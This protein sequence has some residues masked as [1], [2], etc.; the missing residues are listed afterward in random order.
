LFSESGLY[1]FL[2][3]AIPLDP[4]NAIQVTIESDGLYYYHLMPSTN[5]T[6]DL[7]FH[8]LVEVTPTN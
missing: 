1:N 3:I 5:F 2:E 6:L 4:V 8:K 7:T